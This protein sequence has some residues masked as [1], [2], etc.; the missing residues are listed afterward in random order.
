MNAA[1]FRLR[2]GSSEAWSLYL[3]GPLTQGRSMCARA[4]RCL[5][6]EC[7]SYMR[8]GTMQNKAP[9]SEAPIS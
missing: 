3:A 4:F 5:P 1:A 9:M 2:N 6:Y 7:K 8:D